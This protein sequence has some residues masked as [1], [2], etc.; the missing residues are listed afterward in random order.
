[1]KRKMWE[2]PWY[3]SNSNSNVGNSLLRHNVGNSLLR[4]TLACKFLMLCKDCYVRLKNFQITKTTDQTTNT[5]I[6]FAQK[7]FWWSFMF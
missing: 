1:M 7:I 4:V 5:F 6:T 3:S 2:K